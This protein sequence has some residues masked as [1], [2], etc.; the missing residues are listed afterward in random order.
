M[1]TKADDD[2]ELLF[3]QKDFEEGFDD[4]LYPSPSEEMDRY[5]PAVR[6][7]LMELIGEIVDLHRDF[8]EIPDLA[9][10][11]N[12]RDVDEL[13]NV[14]MDLLSNPNTP[15]FIRNCATSISLDV[16]LSGA[17]HPCFEDAFVEHILTE[18][19]RSVS[20]KQPIPPSYGD[21]LE[22]ILVN[23]NEL[24]GR[25]I[26][27]RPQLEAKRAVGAIAEATRRRNTGTAG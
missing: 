23:R 26:K 21:A 7:S 18:I 16:I 8:G 14:L 1:V 5:D 17:K 12:V 20:E 4:S 6:D 27:Q 10:R 11:L 9:A 2:D 25:H 13:K 22:Y 19:E 24:L 15:G 3:E